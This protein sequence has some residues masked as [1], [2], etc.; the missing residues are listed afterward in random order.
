M[1]PPDKLLRNIELGYAQPVL[2]RYN[3]N[4]VERRCHIPGLRLVNIKNHPIFPDQYYCT[5][6]DHHYTLEYQSNLAAVPD[7][8]QGLSPDLFE[9]LHTDEWIHKTYD[10]IGFKAKYNW[11]RSEECQTE[12]RRLLWTKRYNKYCWFIGRGV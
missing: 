6:S 3:Y 2:L 9:K 12:S 11:V 7:L 4:P 1:E 8:F 10:L 5:W